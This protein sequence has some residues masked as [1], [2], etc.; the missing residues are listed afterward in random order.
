M[1]YLPSIQNDFW[2]YLLISAILFGAIQLFYVFN[3]YAR[4]ALKKQ[5]APENRQQYP[6]ISVIIAA[7]NESDNLYEHLPV[8][9]SQDYPNYEVIVVNNQSIDDSN[10]ILTAFAQQFAQLKVVE[11]SRSPHLKPGKKLPITLGIKAATYEFFV[12]TDADCQPLSNQ[13]LKN[14]IDGSSSDHQF[15]IGYSPFTKNKGF[16]NKLVRYDNAW[17]GTN[18]FAYALAGQ[19]FKASGRNIAYT[20]QLFQK[21]NGFKSHYAISPGDDDL[22]LQDALRYTKA[23]IVDDPSSF[24]RSAA[25]STWTNWFAQKAKYHISSARYPVIK[26]VMLGIYP[27]SLILMWISFVALCLNLN[28]LPISTSIFFGIIAIK[29]WLQGACLNRL[30]EKKLMFFFPLWDLFYSILMPIV[31]YISERQKYYRW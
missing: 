6:P 27:L 23:S 31:Y 2:A 1:T 4:F 19:P 25:P 22:L 13:W 28:Y 12:L 17:M 26:K 14:M 20:Q 8:I 24:V 3:F 7:R 30:E 11:I 5:K 10:W 15:V 9:L 16:L 21:V 29:W 18:A